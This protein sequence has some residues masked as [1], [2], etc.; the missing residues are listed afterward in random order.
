MKSSFSTNYITWGLKWVWPPLLDIH[1]HYFH[2]S[3]AFVSLFSMVNDESTEAIKACDN[4]SGSLWE[5]ALLFCRE[6]K[7]L[8]RFPQIMSGCCQKPAKPRSHVPFG[9][10]WHSHGKSPF[11][12][13][14][15]LFSWAISHGE[16][17]NSQSHVAGFLNQTGEFDSEILWWTNAQMGR[18]RQTWRGGKR[19]RDFTKMAMG[20]ADR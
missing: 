3:M 14:K 9:Y 20:R 8:G 10:D 6:L 7:D 15:A 11:L 19:L 13:G 5:S 4:S 16:L 1:A 2:I 18:R 12:I 17:L